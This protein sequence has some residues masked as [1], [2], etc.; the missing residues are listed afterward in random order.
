MRNGAI[1]LY[2]FVF[3]WLVMFFHFDQKHFPLG[4]IGV[5]FFVLVSGFY[6]FSKWERYR[7]AH[8]DRSSYLPA[9][10]KKRYLR[11]LPYTFL[12]FVFTFFVRRIWLVLAQGGTIALNA[13]LIDLSG[14]VWEILLID[15]LGF[16]NGS[17]MLNV[18]TWT[19]SC[20]LIVEFA[21]LCVLTYDEKLFS[22]LICP[23]SLLV[24]FGYWRTMEAANHELW[25]GAMTFGTLR[26][27]LI[28]CLSYYGY[29]IALRIKRVHFTRAGKALL[30]AIEAVSL[31]LVVAIA[32]HY[33][34]RN[35][36]WISTLLLLGACAI[37][38][39]ER[40]FSIKAFRDS[41][42]TRYLGQLSF[43]VFLIHMPILSI[44]EFCFDN[45]T[46]HLLSYCAVVLL[47]SVL[48]LALVDAMLSA[49]RGLGGLRTRLVRDE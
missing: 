11:F 41:R 43:G 10:M 37:A 21:V 15:M 17:Q 34:S 48:L 29:H 12:A 38:F 16:N 44:Y 26:V 30:T 24:G 22:R 18:P 46:E 5:E 42:L 4:K 7:S 28:T 1:D 35:F 25:I 47:S 2:R 6:F 33:S 14:D 32:M 49:L 23:L 36:Q 31:L 27:W 19:V 3:C 45:V 20:M 13:L 40:S 9:Y 39:S 8:E